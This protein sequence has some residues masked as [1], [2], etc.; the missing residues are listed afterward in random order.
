MRARGAGGPHR[1]PQG[2]DE[3]HHED[4]AGADAAPEDLKP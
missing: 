2:E 3:G 1:R 4:A